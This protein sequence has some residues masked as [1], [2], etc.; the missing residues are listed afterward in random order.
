MIGRPPRST[1]FPY[2]TLFRSKTE[3]SI[4]GAMREGR[5]ERTYQR[6]YGRTP[7]LAMRQI[8]AAA[9]GN[10]LIHGVTW[11]ACVNLPHRLI[12][13]NGQLLRKWSDVEE[14]IKWNRNRAFQMRRIRLVRMHGVAA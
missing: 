6:V 14:A 13:T 11:P 4:S 1:L 7:R 12:R 8:V 10:A 2:T 9:R 5:L 3:L